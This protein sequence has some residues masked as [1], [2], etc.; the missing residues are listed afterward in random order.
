MF[1]Q[2]VPFTAQVYVGE[3][4]LIG[5]KSTKTQNKSLRPNFFVRETLEVY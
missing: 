2:N 3:K 4:G 5:L 1:I